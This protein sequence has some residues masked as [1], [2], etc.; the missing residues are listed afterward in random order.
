MI[1]AFSQLKTAMAGKVSCIR[2]GRA[3]ITADHRI[4]LPITNLFLI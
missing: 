4:V 3:D 1:A 2:I